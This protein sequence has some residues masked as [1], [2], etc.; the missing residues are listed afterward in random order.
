MIY[1]VGI[2]LVKIDRIK[3]SITRFGDRF[4]KRI[5]T[6]SELSAA[7][8]LVKNKK[9]YYSF[10]AKRFAAKEA[11]AKAWGS[12]IGEKIQ[13]RGIEILSD[14]LGKPYI[15][16]CNVVDGLEA[17]YKAHL[18]ISDTNE[19]AIAYVVIEKL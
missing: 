7:Q 12:G 3:N 18:S 15:K 13:F 16:H 14:S 11:Y 19:H 8:N 17:G 4:K 6:N 2:D 10:F 1:G 9:K 5:Y